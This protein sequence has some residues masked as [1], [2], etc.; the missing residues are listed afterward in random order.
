MPYSPDLDP[1]CHNLPT[2]PSFPPPPKYPVNLVALSDYPNSKWAGSVASFH[3][4]FPWIQPPDPT[5]CLRPLAEQPGAQWGCL[6]GSMKRYSRGHSLLTHSRLNHS[7]VA[8][9]TGVR[10]W[11][12]GY[13]PK[14]SP[15]LYWGAFDWVRPLA[16]SL[17]RSLNL[18]LPQSLT[19][20]VFHLAPLSG[21]CFSGT[22]V[23]YPPYLIPLFLVS[24]LG[25]V[26]VI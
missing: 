6:V 24:F 22:K 13:S 16:H 1:C 3:H 25:S 23:R 21:D 20:L 8:P 2:T 14:L 12:I 5:V 4:I 9:Q 10:F 15:P 19:N 7:L 18:S 26:T 11:S 17:P